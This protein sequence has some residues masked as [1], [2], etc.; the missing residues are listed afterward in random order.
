MVMT[1]LLLALAALVASALLAPAAQA[2]DCDIEDAAD[3]R[4]CLR[5]A[6]VPA[7]RQLVPP[8]IRAPAVRSEACD[9]DEVEDV[10]KCLRGLRLPGLRHAVP[11]EVRPA[12]EPKESRPVPESKPEVARAAPAATDSTARQDDGPKCR[13]Y[14]PNVGQMVLVPCGE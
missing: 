11:S 1:R 8:S 6:K 9:P 13:K 2:F 4:E 7:I 12:V 5:G 14:F 3:L 10:A